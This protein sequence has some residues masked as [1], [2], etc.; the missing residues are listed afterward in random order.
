MAIFVFT[1][2]ADVIL[3]LLNPIFTFFSVEFV[4]NPTLASCTSRVDLLSRIKHIA[5]QDT[6][7][8]HVDI[9]WQWLGFGFGS[10]NLLFIIDRRLGRFICSGKLPH[11]CVSTVIVE[12]HTGNIRIIQG[13]CA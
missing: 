13:T 5:K 4:R 8:C 9:D 11:Q 12:I 7:T 1:L 6:S 10:E 3:Q 2:S